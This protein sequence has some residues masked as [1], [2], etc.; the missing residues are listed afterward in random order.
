MVDD[1]TSINKTRLGAVK[2]IQFAIDT[3]NIDDEMLAIAG[4]NVFTL[5]SLHAC[6]HLAFILLLLNL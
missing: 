2:D 5:K 1:G 6:N 4:D 3:L